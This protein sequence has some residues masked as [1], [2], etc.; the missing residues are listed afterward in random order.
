MSFGD[1]GNVALLAQKDCKGLQ[2]LLRLGKDW[3]EGNMETVVTI[4]KSTSEDEVKEI[5]DLLMDRWKV[6]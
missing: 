4:T 2:K 3:G 5:M 6:F 1:P